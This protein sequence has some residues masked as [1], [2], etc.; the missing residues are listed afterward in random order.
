MKP[1]DAQRLRIVPCDLKRAN[2]YVES[3]HRHHQPV[4]SA[5]FCLAVAD[6]HA[7]VRGVAIVNRPVARRLDDG[8]TLEVQ[9]VATDGCPNACSALYGAVSRVAKVL[10]YARVYTYIRDDEPGS[11]LRGSGW[12]SDEHGRGRDLLRARSWNATTRPRKDKHE[13]APTRR[14]VWRS[15]SSDRVELVWIEVEEDQLSLLGEALAPALTGGNA[16]AQHRAAVP[17]AESPE[18]EPV[19]RGGGAA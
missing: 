11:S 1:L 15:S 19:V 2:S 6:E 12:V 3:L 13:P 18:D 7:V 4:G 16:D 10:G 8:W 14:W 5:R 9:R 17:R